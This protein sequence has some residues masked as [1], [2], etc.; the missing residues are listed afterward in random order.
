MMVRSAPDGGSAVGI[1]GPSYDDG[2]S[3]CHRCGERMDAEDL[4]V[5]AFEDF[6]A[7]TCGPCADA[8]W[9]LAD[10]PLNTESAN[11]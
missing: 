5:E 4:S 10:D 11:R 7:L 6:G 8:L 1:W 3:V 9:E 2:T